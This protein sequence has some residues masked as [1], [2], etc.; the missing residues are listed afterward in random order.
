[1]RSTG[2]RSWSRP[3]PTRAGGRWSGRTRRLPTGTCTPATTRRLWR[4]RSRNRAHRSH[5]TYRPHRPL[6]QNPGHGH[7][8]ALEGHLQLL[9]VRGEFQGRG[10]VGVPALHELAEVLGEVHHP[11][12]VAVADHVPDLVVP[13]L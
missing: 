8:D 12:L 10:P 7:L 13:R 3:T 1:R 4:C 5:E 2:P 6:R 11:L 9:R